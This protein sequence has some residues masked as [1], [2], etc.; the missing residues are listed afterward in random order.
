MSSVVLRA[1]V[2]RLL[3]AN[4]AALVA[5]FN[6][7]ASALSLP[8][9]A[10]RSPPRH[11]TTASTSIDAMCTPVRLVRFMFLLTSFSGICLAC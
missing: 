6:H 5:V 1:Q 9:K 8:K 11:A 10:Q 7:Y 4:R 3:K 2:P